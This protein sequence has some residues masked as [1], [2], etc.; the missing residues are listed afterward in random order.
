MNPPRPATKKP[1]KVDNSPEAIERR[2]K[3]KAKR[4]RNGSEWQDQI[5][6]AVAVISNFSF[7]PNN[8]GAGYGQAMAEKPG[9]RIACYHG[10]LMLIEA[11][12][13]EW[14]KDA[15]RNRLER[16]DFRFSEEQAL[17]EVTCDGGLALVAIRLKLDPAEPAHDQAWLCHYADLVGHMRA[18]GEVQVRLDRERPEFLVPIFRRHLKGH[19]ERWD[20]KP[21]IE[22]LLRFVRF[23]HPQSPKVELKEQIAAAKA[24]KKAAREA[25]V[26]RDAVKKAEAEAKKAA[27]AAR[28]AEQ[29]KAL[30]ARNEPSF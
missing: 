9:D 29:L 11:K 17:W 4:R 13:Y 24:K 3:E 22:G 14:S 1:R 25:K 15:W 27:E 16:E 12:D 19:G 6:D 23:P 2:A 7:N 30:M 8:Q 5:R 10:L 26:A 28:I 20:L 21:A 18:R